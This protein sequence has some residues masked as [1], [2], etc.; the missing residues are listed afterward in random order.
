MAIDN[1]N[2]ISQLNATNPD[3]RIEKIQQVDDH[4]R[5]IKKVLLNQF[6]NFNKAI[7]L[8]SDEL[9]NLK[10]VFTITSGQINI[11][12]NNL[13]NVAAVDNGSAVQPRSYNDARY[14]QLSQ[15]L[16]DIPY[17]EGAFANLFRNTSQPVMD[18]FAARL[19][20][21]WPVGSLFFETSGYNPRD[22][23]GFGTWIRYGEGR[24]I[25]SAGSYH[26]GLEAWG[27]SLGQSIGTWQTRLSLEHIPAHKHYMFT[28][29]WNNYGASLVANGSDVRVAAGGVQRSATDRDDYQ[30]MQSAG[31][32][33]VGLTESAGSG[34]A[35]NNVHPTVY[36]NVWVR[37]Q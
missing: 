31:G 26:D 20:R 24:A 5:E 10:S 2:F 7:T 8:T 6:P 15:N 32:G 12:G 30:L 4:I 16:A 29:S 34:A 25:G 3:G 17:K 1:A 28:R 22:R 35:F 9:N 13:I 27:P 21:L 19:Q 36:V 18:E 11:N 33:N 23:L 14:A 37:V